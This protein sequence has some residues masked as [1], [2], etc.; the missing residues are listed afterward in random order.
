M[1]DCQFEILTYVQRAPDGVG[2]EFM[3]I[4]WHTFD[5]TSVYK[6]RMYLDIFES[7]LDSVGQNWTNLPPRR[8][9]SRM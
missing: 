8:V 2:W 1:P 4:Y 9:D 7:V 6:L 3:K 5:L